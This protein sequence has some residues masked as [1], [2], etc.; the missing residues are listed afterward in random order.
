MPGAFVEP[1]GLVL[2][3]PGAN[4]EPPAVPGATVEPPG[5]VP[6]AFVEPSGLVLPEP[7]HNR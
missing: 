5:P 6:G 7:F 4:V 2:P 3:E 1:S